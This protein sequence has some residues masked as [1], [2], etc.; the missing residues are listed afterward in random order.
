MIHCHFDE[1]FVADLRHVTVSALI[2]NDKNQIML[3]KR[4]KHLKNPDKWAMPGGYLDHSERTS[5]GVLREVLEET[6]HQGEVKKLF[7]LNDNPKRPNEDTQNVE[8]LFL[9]KVIEKIQEPDKE[10]QE[11]RWFDLNS[12]PPK[13]EFAF[14]HFED[15][16]LYL[17]HLKNPK[18]LPIFLI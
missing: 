2:V 8:F 18:S 7:Y 3:V 11:V 17:Q 5:Q 4:A 12:L 13:G 1:G 6:G 15:I 10:V 16:E 14:D 9:V